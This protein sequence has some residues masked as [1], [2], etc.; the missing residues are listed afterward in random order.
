MSDFIQLVTTTATRD[1]AETIARHLVEQRLAACVQILG[2]ITSVYRWEGKVETAQEWQ[3]VIKSR[4]SVWP[5]LEAAI[6]S[7]HRYQ[8]PE[9]LAF[10]IEDGHA[11][12]LEWLAAEVPTP[13]EP[14]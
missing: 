14:L 4:R 9:I 12:Y 13:R 11:P 5:Q 7:K 10:A 8:V 6:R 3:C 1:D 2:P